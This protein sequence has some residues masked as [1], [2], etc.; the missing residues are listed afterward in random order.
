MA[1]TITTSSTRHDSFTIERR[2]KAPSA[3]VF[4]A[5]STQE[6]KRAWFFGGEGWIEEFRAFDFR[7]GGSEEL[8]GRKQSGT[9]SAFFCRYWEIIPDRRIVYAY[10]MHMDG[11]RISVSL[12]TIELTPDGSGTHM[13]L[14]EQGAY[15]VAYD[16]NR[17]DNGSRQR[18]T[19]E[20]LD[21][22][23][24]YVDAT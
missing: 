24:A 23:A 6:A 15:L 11:V 17:D 7:E 21:R 22:V 12:A 5:W 9:T 13:T 16:P 19:A 3:R 4:A 8:V 14:T 10:D 20:L 1:V 18:G 2:F